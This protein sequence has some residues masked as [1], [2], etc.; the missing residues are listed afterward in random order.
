[1]LCNTARVTQLKATL[2]STHNRNVSQKIC[3]HS[4]KD[5][6]RMVKAVLFV[7]LKLGSRK[8]DKIW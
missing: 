7:I 5:M 4:A 6:Y 8:M 2:S 3:M 1:M